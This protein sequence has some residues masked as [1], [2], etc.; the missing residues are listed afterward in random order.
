MSQR[1]VQ[2]AVSQLLKLRKE[3]SRSVGAAP[4]NYSEETGSRTGSFSSPRCISCQTWTSRTRGVHSSPGDGIPVALPGETGKRACDSAARTTSERCPVRLL[5]RASF[6]EKHQ[7]LTR[8][9]RPGRCTHHRA[10]SPCNPVPPPR[11]RACRPRPGAAATGHPASRIGIRKPLIE[12]I[13]GHISHVTTEPHPRIPLI[14]HA[15]AVPN[16]QRSPRPP[17]L[18][19]TPKSN[20]QVTDPRAHSRPPRLPREKG[21]GNRV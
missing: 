2:P 12:E 5:R 4:A 19:H 6:Y 8:S 16:P 1:S 7:D 18:G 10:S 14:D 3:Y 9:S 13:P 15:P 21:P 17:H 11:M 20:S